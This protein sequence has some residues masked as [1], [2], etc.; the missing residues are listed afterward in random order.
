[1]KIQENVMTVIKAVLP[2]LIIIILFVIVGQF[3]FGRISSIRDQIASAQRDQK[4]LTQKL[5]ILKNVGS[6]GAQFSNLAAAALPDSNSSL[7]TISQIKILAGNAGVSLSGM[8]AG[9]PALDATGLS[10]ANISFNAAGS[11]TQVESFI[12]AIS[13]FAPISIVDK[14]KTSEATPGIDLASVSVK[15]FWAPFPTKIPEVTSA[16]SGLT[17]DE[18]QTLQGLS[19]LTQP[20]FVIIQAA[21]GGKSDP[22]NQ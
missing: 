21:P 1:M 13:S 10:A 12:K 8:K 14:V 7:S 2:L 4:I 18:Q 22:F 17:A 9:S 19:T 20:V 15:S 6:T 3:G 5:D 16:I 11:R